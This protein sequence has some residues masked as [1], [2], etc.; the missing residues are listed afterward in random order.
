ML[1][2]VDKNIYITQ[3]QDG[4]HVL[5]RWNNFV[6]LYFYILPS[7]IRISSKICTWEMGAQE[8]EEKDV[9]VRS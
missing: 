9:R 2:M 7:C 8:K 6:P 4:G 3:V 5:R 1:T